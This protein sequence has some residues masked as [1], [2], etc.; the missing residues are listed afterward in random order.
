MPLDALLQY[1]ALGVIAAALFAFARTAYRRE[2]D[3]ADRLEAELARLNGLLQER[4]IPAL[5]SANQALHDATDAL[6]DVQR[7]ERR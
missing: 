4:H 3:R 5:L 2:V 6:R 7:R 1:G